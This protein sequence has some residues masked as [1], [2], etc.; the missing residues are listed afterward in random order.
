MRLIAST[1]HDM[2]QPPPG[3]FLPLFQLLA[4]NRISVPPLI[5]R[6][7]DIPALVDHFVRRHARRLGKVIDGVSPDSMRR[8]EAYAWPGNI[9]ELRTV[10]ERAVLLCKSTVLEVDE[11]QLNE[12]L[13]VGSYRLVTPLGSGGMGEVW[14]ARH[15]FLVRPAAV[16]LI[17][18]DVPPGCSARS[19]GAAFRARSAGH[20]G[21]EVAAHRAAV[22][23]RRE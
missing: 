4:A 9:R 7:E 16:K 15:R 3:G 22:R 5:D 19:A 21:A 11:D 14:L 18:H 17:R 12:A 6:R 10:L 20:R 23:L 2:R 13:A 8:L 1:T